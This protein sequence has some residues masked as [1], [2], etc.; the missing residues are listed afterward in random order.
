[1]IVTSISIIFL[2]EFN[3]LLE[4]VNQHQNAEEKTDQANAEK[5]THTTF[6]LAAF[7]ACMNSCSVIKFIPENETLYKSTDI[8]LSSKSKFTNEYNFKEEVRTVIRPKPNK[9]FFGLR[10]GLLMHFK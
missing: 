7:I 4:E 2:K 9:T 3:E 6:L 8:K 1:M 10:F 5:Q